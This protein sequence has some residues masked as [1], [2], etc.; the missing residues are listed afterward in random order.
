VSVF[1]MTDFSAR[2]EVQTDASRKRTLGTALA[3]LALAVALIVSIVMVL[4]VTGVSSSLASTR[5]DLIM[6][7]ETTASSS[8][9]TIGI[10]TVI[11]LVMGVLTVLALRDVAPAHSKRGNRRP[12]RR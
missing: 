1:E 5:S 3:E 2:T 7:E 10:L 11:A 9:T 6:M 4:V 12:T 8:L